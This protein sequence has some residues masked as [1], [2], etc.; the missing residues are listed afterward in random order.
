MDKVSLVVQPRDVTGSRAA[1]RLRKSGL[2]P[3]VL[4]GH[5]KDA[6]LIAVDPHDAARRA[7]HRAPARTPSSTS[8]SRAT[9]AP[10]RPSSRSIAARPPSRAT[11]P[12]STCRRSAWTRPSR[13]PSAVR[14]EGEA[15]GVK[16]GGMLDESIREVTVK[17]IVTGIPEHLVLDISALDMDDTAK[18]SDLVVPE[19]I[20]ILDDP[21]EVLCSVLPPRRSRSRRRR[22][23]GGRRGRRCGR[24]RDRRQA[25]RRG[26][27]LIGPLSGPP[28]AS[29]SW[30]SSARSTSVEY[31]I[32]GL[33]NPGPAYEGTR[34]T[35]A[36]GSSRSWRAGTA[37]RAPGAGSTAAWP[38]GSSAA[39]PC[40]CCSPP[41][42]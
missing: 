2:I 11:S 25:G 40:S 28:D 20:E 9:S 29:A 14:F 41:R 4:Y 13:P 7:H 10:T 8:R 17:G 22:G 37:S 27:G 3:G 33:G 24:A 21:D 12:T 19:G 39:A 32:V 23:R 5:G 36:T 30:R 35:S 38:K 31:L 34:T 18:V 42:S 6:T 16:A 1:K 26:R 15:E